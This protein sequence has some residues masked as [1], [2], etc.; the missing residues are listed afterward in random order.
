MTSTL[1]KKIDRR[2]CRSPH[3][4]QQQ[5]T[6]YQKYLLEVWIIHKKRE[7]LNVDKPPSGNTVFTAHDD[8]NHKNNPVLRNYRSGCFQEQAQTDPIDASPFPRRI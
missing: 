1:A 4:N 6:N 8:K 3:D 5:S 7:Y 2:V